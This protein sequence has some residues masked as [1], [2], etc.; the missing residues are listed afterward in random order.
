VNAPPRAVKGKE[1]GEIALQNQEMENL[2]NEFQTVMQRI[3]GDDNLEKYKQEYDKLYKTLKMSFD[4]EKKLV[5]QS[6]NLNEMMMNNAASVKAALDL[7]T[8]DSNTIK[9]L[10]KE[11]E[12]AWQFVEKAKE[13]EERSKKMVQDLKTEIMHLN[14]IVEQGAALSLGPE[15]NVHDLIKTKEDLTKQNEEKKIS[16]ARFEEE[17]AKIKAEKTEL[18][19]KAHLLNVDLKTNKED[20]DRYVLDIKRKDDK[21]LHQEEQHKNIQNDLDTKE[22]E[23]KKYADDLEERKRDFANLEKEIGSR[24][25]SLERHKSETKDE[26]REERLA[27]EKKREL[28]RRKAGLEESK[29]ISDEEE[30]ELK[31]ENSDLEQLKKSAK[32]EKSKLEQENNKQV[33]RIKTL[34]VEKKTLINTADKLERDRERLQKDID[35][36]R[37]EFLKINADSDGINHKVDVADTKNSQISE[38]LAAKITEKESVQGEL[39]KKQKDLEDLKK[40][41][42]EVE[43][44]KK[45]QFARV[46]QA[47]LSQQKLEAEI[48]LKE[49]LHTEIERKMMEYKEK[50]KEKERLYEM[51]RGDRNL[52]SKNLIEKH[53]EMNELKRKF[54]ITTQQINQLKEELEAKDKALVSKNHEFEKEKQEKDQNAHKVQKNEVEISKLVM[55]EQAKDTD[56]EK[57]KSM[58]KDNQAQ[59]TE[60]NKKYEKAIR[61]KDVYGT[62]LIRRNDEL[63]LLCEK[64]KILQSTLAK[65]EIQYKEIEAEIRLL[66]TKIAENKNSERVLTR[67]GDDVGKLGIEIYSL[68]S[69]L[70]QERMQVQALSEELE[71]PINIHRWRKLEGTDPDTYEMLQKIQALQKR[72]IKKTEEVVDKEGKLQEK[73]SQIQQLKQ[74]LARQPGLETADNINIYQQNLKERTKQMKAMAA[75]LNMYQAQVTFC[76]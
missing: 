70:T 7:S 55:A 48:K 53:D 67:K 11:I 56:I 59:I 35:N 64:I 4:N 69:A 46:A 63:T 38:L 37:L 33:T 27:K 44:E 25:S 1:G 32:N 24:E 62:E 29:G 16:I 40:K 41:K 21:I 42:D 31:K 10:R 51:V 8:D 30:K 20:K 49:N 39:V 3:T 5:K 68:T 52:Y 9:R 19:G 18:E 66:K 61:D 58:I 57:L 23:R 65:G 75:E 60:L 17:I 28:E 22:A 71:N 72:L 26:E 12:K 34:E 45:K 36:E 47:A 14:K 15:N 6:N 13:K 43:K 73:E 50:A 54:D 76:L 2:D 74:M